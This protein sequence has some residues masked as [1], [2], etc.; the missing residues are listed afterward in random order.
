MNAT[1]S[2][3]LVRTF[4]RRRTLWHDRDDAVM[5]MHLGRLVVVA[6]RSAAGVC[7]VAGRLLRIA[8]H[9]EV[10]LRLVASSRLLQQAT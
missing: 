7:V 6:R 8:I 10:Q 4:D 5:A 1:L 2:F 3:S 9:V